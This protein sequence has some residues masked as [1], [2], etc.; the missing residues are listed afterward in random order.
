MK[1]IKRITII[2]FVMLCFFM[3]KSFAEVGIV[4]VPAIRVR[5]NPNTDSNILMN[6]YEDDEVEIIE[7]NGQWS[8]IEFNGNTGYVKT[9]FLKINGENDNNT[10][11]ESSSNLQNTKNEED[12]NL[13]NENN[14]IQNNQSSEDMESKKISVRLLPN[15]ASKVIA[16][17]DITTQIEEQE[18]LNNWIKILS[19]GS[20]TGW[21]L[22]NKLSQN[23]ENTLQEQ[24]KQEEPKQDETKVEQE[25]VEQSVEDNVNKSGKIN[26]ETAKVREKADSTSSVIDFLDYNDEVTIIAEEGEWYKVTSGSI[27]GYVN[28]RLITIN[29]SSRSLSEDREKIDDDTLV[30]ENANNS[31]N[32]ALTKSNNTI[33]GVQ[34]AEYAKQYLGYSYVSGGK[35]PDSGFDC[36]GFTKYVYSNFGYNLGN[37]AAAQNSLGTEIS[38]DNLNIGDLILFYDEGKTKIGHTGIYIGDGIF[39]H[40]ANS[41]RGVVTDNLNTNSYY[42]SRF[43]TA[44]RIIE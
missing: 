44:R 9:E 23:I 38:K 28:K 27:T 5:E 18:E 13:N 30:S 8:K 41:E 14:Q 16:E 6:I 29:V 39:I 20:I 4:N 36:S 3:N 33:T 40:A 21:V 32:D 24:L 31:V 11:L 19:D 37:T 22:K 2:I 10:K 34:V 43:I 42:N 26:V 7:N 15:M 17:I 12:S 1:N 25:K 35:T